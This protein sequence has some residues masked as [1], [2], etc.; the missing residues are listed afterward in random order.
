MN[1]GALQYLVS[2]LEKKLDE[3]ALLKQ[4]GTMELPIYETKIYIPS[5]IEEVNQVF[6]FYYV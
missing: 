1:V 5:S 3:L 4:K 2:G 6:D